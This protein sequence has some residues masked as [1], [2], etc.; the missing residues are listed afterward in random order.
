MIPNAG[1]DAEN[2]YSYAVG[3][4]VNNSVTLEKSLEVPFKMKNGLTI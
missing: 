1:D 3:E 4:N 2:D